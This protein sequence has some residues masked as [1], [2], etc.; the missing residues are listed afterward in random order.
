MMADCDDY[1]YVWMWQLRNIWNTTLYN[2][3]EKTHTTK[4]IHL[5]VSLNDQCQAS[6][7]NMIFFLYMYNTIELFLFEN[8]SYAWFGTRTT[9]PSGAH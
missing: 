7:P 9:Y 3:W 5:H 1:M 2:I 8:N 6:A 4:Q